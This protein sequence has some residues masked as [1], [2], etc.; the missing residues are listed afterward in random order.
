M[1]PVTVLHGAQ[2]SG[3]TQL[4]HVQ[5][6]GEK[7]SKPL[8]A[9]V[10]LSNADHA[11]MNYGCRVTDPCYM[12]DKSIDTHCATCTYAI[13]DYNCTVVLNVTYNNQPI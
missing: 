10:N 3:A 7:E 11:T 12:F 9:T 6:T 13:N 5:M 4:M 8:H 1:R 2:L